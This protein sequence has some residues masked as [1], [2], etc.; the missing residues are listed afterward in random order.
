MD[1]RERTKCPHC[2]QEIIVGAKKCR[3]CKTWLV[4]ECPVCGESVE[5]NAVICPHC[6]EGIEEYRRSLAENRMVSTL[7]KTYRTKSLTLVERLMYVSFIQLPYFKL[8]TLVFDGDHITVIKKK[9]KVFE[10]P[11]SESFFKIEG[12]E[13]QDYYY[14]KLM[15]GNKMTRVLR[16]NPMLSEQEWNEIVYQLRKF[17]HEILKSGIEKALDWMTDNKDNLLGKD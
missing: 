9:G 7:H 2:G 15:S 12:R 3:Y 16:I 13:E 5:P 1:T 4:S 10:A 8:D 14:L 11:L 17:G 6:H